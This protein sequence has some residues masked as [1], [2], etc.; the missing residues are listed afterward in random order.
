M[1]S[2]SVP[3]AQSGFSYIEMLIASMLVVV[4]LAPA[5]ESLHS[6][7]LAATAHEMDTRLHYALSGKLETVLAEPISSLLY[8]AQAAGGPTKPSSYSDP[9]AQPNRQVIY[10]SF[11]DIANDDGDKNHFTIAD[12]NT[13]GDNDPYTGDGAAID[14]VWVSAAI[15]GTRHRLESLV[16]R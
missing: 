8:A 16:Q 2:G 11:Y 7:R 15:P 1:F 5:I 4:S 14:V 10:L 12:T 13:D 3:T 6:A 9:V